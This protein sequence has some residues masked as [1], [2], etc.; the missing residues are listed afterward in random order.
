MGRSYRNKLWNCKDVLS[1]LFLK[2][3]AAEEPVDLHFITHGV[4]LFN[5][6]RFI[7]S[8]VK[9]KKG[10]LKSVINSLLKDKRYE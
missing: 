9:Y 6:M 5:K 1:Y 3:V 10:V 2:N 4:F 7:S 8:Q